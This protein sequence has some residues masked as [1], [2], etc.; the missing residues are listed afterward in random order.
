[1][2]VQ[3]FLIWF[4]PSKRAQTAWL[5]LSSL[6]SFLS[7]AMAVLVL[8]DNLLLG[9]D[10]IYRLTQADTLKTDAIVFGCRGNNPSAYSAV[11]FD[12]NQ[13]VLSIEER[14]SKLRPQYT[15][16]YLYL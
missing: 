16:P 6:E 10:L 13:Q 3:I 1:V 15:V 12:D 11:E 7:D 9:Q 5:I 4:T 14:P 2:A 8:G